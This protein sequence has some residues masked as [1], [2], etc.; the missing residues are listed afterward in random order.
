MQRDKYLSL[1]LH[2][3]W[4]EFVT[5]LW[6]NS[7]RMLLMNVQHSSFGFNLG[8]IILFYWK[9]GC[10]LKELI[11]VR[12]YFSEFGGLVKFWFQ[13]RLVMWRSTKLSCFSSFWFTL[14]LKNVCTCNNTLLIFKTF[15]YN[16]L[17]GIHIFDLS[18]KWAADQPDFY[19]YTQTF[20]GHNLT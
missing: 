11:F 8:F 16:I 7:C 10:T 20:V 3:Y 14:F 17:Q 4:K 18:S 5:W 9:E 6:K 15:Q 12:T 1:F 2:L 19:S 13:F